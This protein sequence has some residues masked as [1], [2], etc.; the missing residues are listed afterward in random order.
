MSLVISYKPLFEVKI[1]HHYFL[2]KGAT[3]FDDLPADDQSAL[4]SRYDVSSFFEIKP[5]DETLMTLSKYRCVFKNTSAGFLVGVKIRKNETGDF[6]PF[7]DFAPDLKFTFK[8]RI[9]DRNFLNYTSLPLLN[10]S[11]KIYS[12][13]NLT[14]G[15]NKKYPCLA[16]FAPV[17]DGSK[18]Y[19][20]G[21]LVRNNATDLAKL[22]IAKK[23]TIPNPLTD[24]DAWQE[25]F[26][27][28]P[29]SYVNS[30]DMV[31]TCKG[32]LNYTSA[33]LNAGLTA[34]IKNKTGVT[35]TPRITLMTVPK[36][37]DPV[38]DVTMMQFDFRS[39]PGDFYSIKTS[40]TPDA[41]EYYYSPSGISD[42]FGIMEIF[43][44]SDDQHY[45][46][47]DIN[48]HLLKDG[49][50]LVHPVYHLRFKNRSTMWRYLGKGYPP[51]GKMTGPYP[52]TK[53]GIIP[54]DGLP[55]PSVQMILTEMNDEKTAY[56]TISETY[57]N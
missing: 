53:Y 8:I 41:V 1:I 51:S 26:L 25:D 27:S 38:N 35:V 15:N 40:D 43:I 57:I 30:N 10:N 21:D 29:T 6:L 56:N 9:T 55:N 20:S 47:V 17:F 48:G 22:Y 45:S 3:C 2:D 13:N 14:E 7:V 24:T 11:G 32:I 18:K 23:I 42:L 49:V 54:V 46:P 5:T 39:L 34:I 33:S 52:L 12:F 19:S 50:K 31:D 16:K 4:L 28:L 44:N 36:P 37:G